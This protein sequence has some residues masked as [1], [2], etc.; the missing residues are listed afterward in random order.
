MA[1][2]ERHA[3]GEEE[4]SLELPSLRSAFRRRKGRAEPAR[5]PAEPAPGLP[6]EQGSAL[7]DQDTSILPGAMSEIPVAEERQRRRRD[8][9]PFRL[10]LP[11]PLV[12]VVTGA[13]VG[14]ALVGLTVASLHACSSMRG[15]SSCG[16]PGIL[17]LLVITVAMVVLGSLLLLVAG[18]S[19]PG[20]TS[21][22]GV[23]LLVVLILLALLPVLDHWWVVIVVPGLAMVT[24]VASWWLTTTYSEPGERA[25]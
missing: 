17:L 3:P 21:F 9:T 1:D 2:D 6:P 25:G 20:S 4:P 18:V 16:K 23:G 13:I 11:G 22:L 24:F 14:L 10:R 12:A 15:T 5:E 8:R 19:A 7:V